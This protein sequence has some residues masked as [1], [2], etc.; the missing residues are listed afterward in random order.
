MHNSSTGLGWDLL[1]IINDDSWNVFTTKWRDGWG[2]GRTLF[3]NCTLSLSHAHTHEC[4]HTYTYARTHAH[5]HTHTSLTDAHTLYPPFL[6]PI[7]NPSQV[8]MQRLQFCS[9]FMAQQM[10]GGKNRTG[11]CSQTLRW[12]V[13]A[14][15]GG[16]LNVNQHPRNMLT[17]PLASCCWRSFR[18]KQ[19]LPKWLIHRKPHQN[20]RNPHF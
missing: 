13:N 19:L 7:L 3:W 11:V 12:L 6:Y 2:G 8:N 10:K 17:S 9:L 18:G 16:N 15:K 14:N 20:A 5:T 1:R 4:T